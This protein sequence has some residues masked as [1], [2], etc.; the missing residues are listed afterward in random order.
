MLDHHRARPQRLR[1]VAEEADQHAVLKPL[2]VDLE[3][4]DL[5]DAGLVQNAC[6]PQRRHLDCPPAAR[7][8]AEV[9]S[10]DMPAAALAYELPVA[11][12]GGS[13]HQAHLRR[14]RRGVIERKP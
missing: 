10:T 11:V 5:A 1:R 12:T 13:L 14:L 7:A 8:A 9:R 3:R 6:Q 2:D 4:I